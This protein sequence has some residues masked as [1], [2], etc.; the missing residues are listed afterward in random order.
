[1]PVLNSYDEYSQSLFILLASR[2][3]VD[4]HSL[5]IFTTSRTV[6]ICRGKVTFRSGHVLRV[7]EQ[8]PHIPKLQSTHPH[9]KHVQPD[10]KHNRVPVPSM[11]F[12]EPNLPRLI[13]EVEQLIGQEER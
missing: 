4:H 9:H 12:D 1:M 10:I 3:S 8:N 6:G 7:F 13:D 5:T 2:S 11:S